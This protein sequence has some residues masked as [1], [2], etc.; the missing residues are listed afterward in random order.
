MLSAAIHWRLARKYL[1]RAYRAA[2]PNAKLK[3]L[4]LAVRNS[5]RAQIIE[6][7]SIASE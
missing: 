5:M 1:D 3:Y 4:Q 2:T 6:A 7:E